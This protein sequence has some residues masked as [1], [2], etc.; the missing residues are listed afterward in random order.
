MGSRVRRKDDTSATGTGRLGRQIFPLMYKKKGWS[1]VCSNYNWRLLTEEGQLPWWPPGRSYEKR[2][3][4][5]ERKLE[6]VLVSVFL[7]SLT[8][9]GDLLRDFKQPSGSFLS[10]RISDWLGI[11]EWEEDGTGIFSTLEGCGILMLFIY[12][13]TTS[14][15][16][17][18]QDH[19][20]SLGCI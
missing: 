6:M 13:E 19:F 10:N 17:A 18:L 12:T 7:P 9:K 16:T 8:C 14:E 5:L 15:A 3:G 2:T 11:R 4:V 20:A 1:L